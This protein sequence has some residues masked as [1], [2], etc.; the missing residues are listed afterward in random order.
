VARPIPELPPSTT[1]VL[2][3]KD[4]VPPAAVRFGAGG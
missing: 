4:I 3:D 1:T 2:F